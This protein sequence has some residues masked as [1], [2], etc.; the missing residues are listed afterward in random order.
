MTT[1]TP[2]GISVF[3]FA[4]D[5]EVVPAGQAIFRE[6]DPGDVMFVVKE[7]DVDI[8][9]HGTVVDTVGPGGIFGEMALIDHQPR[10]ASAV[11]TV[12]S[13]LVRIDERRF[14]YLVERTPHFA[15]EVMR[16]MAHRLR[17]MDARA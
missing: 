6:G 15:L 16:I 9:V 12:D 11:A 8:V 5:F 3:R 4:T 17:R 7:G 14:Q 10:S 1:S 2:P 13:Q